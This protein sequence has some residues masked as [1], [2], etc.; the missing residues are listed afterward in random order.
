[1]HIKSPGHTPLLVQVDS[2]PT[3]QAPWLCTSNH[4]PNTH[5]RQRWSAPTRLKFPRPNEP[6]WR[7]RKSM[8]IGICDEH[9]QLGSSF[10]EAH[11]ARRSAPNLACLPHHTRLSTWQ[12]GCDK[13]PI[14]LAIFHSA[15]VSVG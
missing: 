3:L 14:K 4:R 9:I 10:S 5:T 6:S 15:Q 13:P 8:H 12:S 2:R 7:S 11:P 1:T